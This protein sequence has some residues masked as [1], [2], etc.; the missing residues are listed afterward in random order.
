[1]E[2]IVKAILNGAFT[3]VKGPLFFILMVS[4]V[5]SVARHPPGRLAPARVRKLPHA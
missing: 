3:A 4:V 1:M 5:L 2:K